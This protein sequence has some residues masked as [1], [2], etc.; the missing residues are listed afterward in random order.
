M[1]PVASS[2]S[3]RTFSHRHPAKKSFVRAINDGPRNVFGIGL[4]GEGN[5]DQWNYASQLAGDGGWILLTFAGVDNT[6][7]APQQSWVDA[8][9]GV[10]KLNLNPV[11]RLSPPWGQ[12][13]YRSESDDA[14]H[15]DYTTLAAAFKSV[16]A[17]LPLVD[18]QPLYI[19]VGN[20]PDLCYEW[21]C[22]VD[23]GSPLQYDTIAV[24]YAHFFSDVAD[25]LHSIGDERIKVRG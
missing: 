21:A 5:Q 14:D 22:A 11:V 3:E 9:S 18:S 7:V 23:A 2:S 1:L 20:E 17:G 12:G 8:I 10:Q 4:V 24:E 25:A 19:Q 16:V 6:T 13:H 15:H